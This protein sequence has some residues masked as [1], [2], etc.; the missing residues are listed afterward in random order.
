MR[1]TEY[2]PVPEPTLNLDL[3]EE[4][5]DKL[6]PVKTWRISQLTHEDA[7]KLFAEG[8]YPGAAKKWEGLTTDARVFTISIEVDCDTSLL[9][10]SYEKL[11]DLEMP[12]FIQVE[13]VKGK[14]CY[15][16]CAGIFAQMDESTPYMTKII[17]RLKN[18]F[19][20]AM[21]FSR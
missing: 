3:P 21:A 4:E 9:K 10:N 7:K 17:E 13:K 5:Q 18:S 15:R 20:F 8:D 19:P 14:T 12:V 16:L 6:L 11:K 1:G 2:K